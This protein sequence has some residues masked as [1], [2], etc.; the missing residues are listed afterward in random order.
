MLGQLRDSLLERRARAVAFSLDC[1]DREAMRWRRDERRHHG[2]ADPRPDGRDRRA[3][4]RRW[5]ATRAARGRVA[6]RQ[7]PP[8]TAHETVRFGES[9]GLLV[10]TTPAYSPE[11]NGMAEAF[12]KTLQAR[13]RVPEPTRHRRGVLAQLPRW[14]DDYNEVH[15]HKG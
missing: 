3:P 4:L 13:L 7:R 6:Q 10:C 11:S 1:C 8:Y 5:H 9:L 14:F 12:V 15:P 2:R